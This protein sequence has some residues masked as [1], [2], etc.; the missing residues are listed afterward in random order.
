MEKDVVKLV[1]FNGEDFGYW[2]NRTHNYFLSQGRVIWEII[3]EAYMILTM[4]NNTTQGELT[5]YENAYRALNLITI[6]LGRNVYIS[7]RIFLCSILHLTPFELRFGRKSSVSHLRPFGCKCFVMK[8]GNLDKFDSRSSNDILLG[9]TP[10]GR[11]YRVF[12]LKTNTVIESYDVT[13]NEF[14]PC[15]RDVFECAGDKEIEESIV[16]DEKLQGDSD[17]D[18]PLCPSTSSPELVLAST[19]EIEAP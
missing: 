15:P 1:I 10:H 8:C 11:S 3:Q 4:L 16:V 14:A 2:K 6:A 19:L 18:D 9:Y 17:E 13:F 5:R 7:N 12:N